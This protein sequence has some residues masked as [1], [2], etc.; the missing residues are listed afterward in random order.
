MEN[1][2]TGIRCEK[3]GQEVDIEANGNIVEMIILINVLLRYIAEK[4][5]FSGIELA[6]AIL[7]MQKENDLGKII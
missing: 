2:I 5:P 7:K 4:T 3:R 6:E 1:D